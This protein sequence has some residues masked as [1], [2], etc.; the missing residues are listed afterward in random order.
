MMKSTRFMN[1]LAVA[2]RPV[3]P[4]LLVSLLLLGGL[5]GISVRQLFLANYQSSISLPLS[6]DLATFR[7]AQALFSSPAMFEKYGVKHKLSSNIDFGII[8]RQFALNLS[9]PIRIEHTFRLL[10]KDVRDL[11]EMP[12][13]ELNRQIGFRRGLQSDVH[14]YATA[15]EP[16]AAIRL[17]KLAMGYVRESLAAASLRLSLQQWGPAAR[18]EL[19][20][21]RELLAKAKTDLDSSNR[22]IERMERIRDR[23]KDEKDF[24]VSSS[25]SPPV[26]VQVTGAHNLSPLQRLIGLETDRAEQMEELRSAELDLVRLETL[27]RYSDLFQSRVGDGASIDLA[28][29]M[30]R[31][32]NQFEGAPQGDEITAKEEARANIA[33]QM[34]VILTRFSETQTHPLEPEARTGGIGRGLAV[35]FGLVAGAA[36]WLLLVLLLPTPRSRPDEVT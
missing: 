34:Q 15:K 36:A 33:Q 2:I 13:D 23:F 29:E 8:H 11:P 27:V 16:E 32:A 20:K 5:A 12:K 24:S 28:K 14:V 9:S 26:Q 4:I 1:E 18:A 10:R 6:G 21:K 25:G 7:E 35:L 31:H 19:A 17:A 22:R 30:L 3:R